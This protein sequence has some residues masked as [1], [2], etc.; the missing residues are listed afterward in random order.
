M[1][2]M[3]TRG[4]WAL[5][6]VLSSEHSSMATGETAPLLARAASISGSGALWHVHERV[7]CVLRALIGLA[8]TA[9]T[10]YE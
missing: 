2:S 8:F 1:S 4:S 7:E 5:N 10:V 6:H 9:L 3:P